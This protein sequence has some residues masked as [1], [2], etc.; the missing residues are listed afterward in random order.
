MGLTEFRRLKQLEEENSK[1]K[2]RMANL[3]MDET[4]LQDALRKS[5]E[6][7]P[8]PRGH[9]PLTQLPE[10]SNPKRGIFRGAGQG[11]DAGGRSNLR[12]TLLSKAG[13]GEA[14]VNQY[15]RFLVT[16]LCTQI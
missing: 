9:P 6:A 12:Q 14:Q 4:T 3:T 7:R 11:C 2:R 13:P 8:A 10:N 5:G 1:L 15:E 16:A